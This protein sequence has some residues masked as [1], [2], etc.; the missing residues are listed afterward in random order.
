MSHDRE[1]AELGSMLR[2]MVR[3][4]VRRAA[5]GDTEALR[6]LARLQDELPG[7]IT[8]AGQLMHEG[9]RMGGEG[10]DYTTL[11]G[12]LGITRQAARQRFTKAPSPEAAAYYGAPR[13]VPAEPVAELVNVHA[14]NSTARHGEHS[15]TMLPG[16]Y[17]TCPGR[18]L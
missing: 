8:V 15:W 7:A 9:T 11:A 3:A 4:L 10:Y 18:A 12:E 1:S 14:C 5:E 16:E 17:A 6:E 13:R 2:R